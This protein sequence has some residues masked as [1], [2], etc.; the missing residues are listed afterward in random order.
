MDMLQATRAVRRMY[1]DCTGTAA[2]PEFWWFSVFRGIAHLALNSFDI[3]AEQGTVY[4]G[5]SLSGAF[6][7]PAESEQQALTAS[8]APRAESAAQ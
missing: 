1:A 6:G 4:L 5:A 3:Y 2:R 8:T 7:L